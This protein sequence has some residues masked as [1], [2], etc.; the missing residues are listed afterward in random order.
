MSKIRAKRFRVIKVHMNYQ[1]FF[2]WSNN[3]ELLIPG[4]TF[5]GCLFGFQVGYKKWGLPNK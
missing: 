1:G 3:P 2:V 4:A 5:L